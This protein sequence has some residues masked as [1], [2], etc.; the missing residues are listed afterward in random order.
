MLG[1][2]TNP[3]ALRVSNKNSSPPNKKILDERHYLFF[4]GT[5]MCLSEGAL[6]FQRG[7][8]SG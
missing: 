3:N 1:S 5:F 2:T 8:D 4:L 6:R 7:S